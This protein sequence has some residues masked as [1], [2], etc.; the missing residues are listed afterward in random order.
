MNKLPEHVSA[1]VWGPHLSH[2][3]LGY[4]VTQRVLVKQAEF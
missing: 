4:A 2:M 1:T 3:D